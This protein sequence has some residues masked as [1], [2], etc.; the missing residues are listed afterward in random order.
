MCA[1]APVRRAASITASMAEASLSGGR[2]AR[3]APYPR[4][5]A[6]S[7]ASSAGSSACTM[8]REPSAA[9][10][11]MAASSCARSRCGNSST[12]DGERKHLKPKTPASCSGASA[13]RLPGT[14][15]PQNPTSMYADAAAAARLIAERLGGRRRR[16]RVQR[17]VDDRRHPTRRR[18]ER[19]R[20]EALPLGAARLVDVHVRVDEARAAAPRRR[21]PAPP[22]RR[23]TRSR[24]PTTSA[25][26]PPSI[27]TA[28][29]RKD[30]PRK[31]LPARMTR[32]SSATQAP[33]DT[34]TD[35]AGASVPASAASRLRP[36]RPHDR[37]V[38]D[39][40]EESADHPGEAAQTAK[41]G[42]PDRRDREDGGDADGDQRAP[43]PP[44]LVEVAAPIRP[45]RTGRRP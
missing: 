43:V 6:P 24:T 34:V 37:G 21:G 19:R 29:G 10:S 38:E 41:R 25:M 17:H 15:P 18:R 16:Q 14:A 9:T 28:A 26:R 8:R 22:A 20:A 13:P 23:A 27:T 5:R 4:P 12:P 39:R 30:P 2:D 42:D 7:R 44:L 35:S 31:V 32:R 3:K 1:R 36:I 11:S 45:S 40:A 33:L